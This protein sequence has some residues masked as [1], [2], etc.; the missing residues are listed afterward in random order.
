MSRSS[1]AGSNERARLGEGQLQLRRAIE[2]RVDVEEVGRV[3]A[4]A[5]GRP[6]DPRTDV[7]RA[8]DPDAAPLGQKLPGLVGLVE[9]APDDDPIRRGF[10]RLGEAPARSERGMAGQSLA[11]ERELEDADRASVHRV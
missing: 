7:A 8:A 9:R 3:E 11:E 10:E 2:R 4:A 5:A 6:I 1:P